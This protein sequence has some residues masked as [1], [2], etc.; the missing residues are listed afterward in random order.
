[1]SGRTKLNKTA[2]TK[3]PNPYVKALC[4]PLKDWNFHE[5]EAPR[6]KG[7]W[8]E[9]VFQKT[10]S[11]LL[12]LEIGLG[13]GLGFFNLL[14]SRPE[15]SFLGL[16]LKYKP[17]AQT[18]RRFRKADFRHARVIRYN[19]RLITDLFANGELNDI[20]LHFPD[21]WPKR[22]H[23]KHRLVDIGFAAALFQIQRQGSFL[24][25][26]TDS[27]NYFS[28]SRELFSKVGYKTLVCNPDLHSGKRRDLEFLESLSQFE[29]I[30]V[31]QNIPIKY[32]LLEKPKAFGS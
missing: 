2:A 25:F 22:R 11:D 19:A 27:E 14:Q 30:F 24:E 28:R 1:M 26:K 17:L 16:D 15:D 8:R 7:F 3:T 31:R 23:G 9:R 20:F 18:I 6:F 13:N 29:R 32:L 5:E 12:H 10:T 21:P 4:D